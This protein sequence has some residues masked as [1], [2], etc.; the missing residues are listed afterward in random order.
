M[1]IDNRRA[2]HARAENPEICFRC[3]V[4]SAVEAWRKNGYCCPFCASWFNAAL[5]PRSAARTEV[6]AATSEVYLQDA[7]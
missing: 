7:L 5:H 4:L 6:E 3:G 1:R 2:L